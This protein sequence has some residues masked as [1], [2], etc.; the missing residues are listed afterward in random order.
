MNLKREIKSYIAQFAYSPL[1]N[2]FILLVGGAKVYAEL[3]V[4][5]SKKKYLAEAKIEFEKGSKFGDLDDY[6][7]VLNRWWFSYNEY[8]NQYELY[9]KSENDRDKF[10]SRLKMAYYHWRYSS[11]TAKGIF[12][13][14]NRFLTT[15]YKYI[16][17]K[18][19]YAPESSYEEFV[20]LTSNYDCVVKPCDGK[21]G[22]GIFKLYKD[23]NHNDYQKLYASCVKDKMLVEQCIESC[24]DLK[25][26]H[27][28]SLNTIRVV[29]IAN[30]EKSEV[31]GSFLRMGRGN[32]V[33]DN[34]HAGGIFAQIN[35]QD[36][37]IESDG[38]D[39]NG[40]RYV[41]HPDSNIKLKGFKIPKWENVVAT[42]CEVAKMA[43]NTIMGWDVAINNQGEIEF[44]EA[45]YGPDF[46]V[47]QSPLK[48]GVKEK[49]FSK[50][51]EYS[52]VEMK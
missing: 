3:K 29:T 34:A 11:G 30:R 17:R 10:V 50:I 51:K 40:Y 4:W 33:V 15:Y 27:P 41:Y 37:T 8:V 44:V 24:E 26:F 20:Q 2:Q 25:A 45:N 35:I 28:Q 22:R 42:C 6:R 1:G 38:I 7:Q 52:G 14:K 49:I 18:W 12:R 9:N 48:V 19:L 5:L 36:G 47:M 31:F 46:D 16:H 39:T 43:G 21:L 32:S 13:N 23:D